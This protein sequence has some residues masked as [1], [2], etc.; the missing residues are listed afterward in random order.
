MASHAILHKRT[1]RRTAA[2]TPALQILNDCGDALPSN[3]VRNHVTYI[4]R[5]VTQHNQPQAR[6]SLPS[7]TD[8][9]PQK[10]TPKCP[11]ADGAEPI[12]TQSYTLTYPVHMH[13]C[14]KISP[15]FPPSP[16]QNPQ[17]FP[18][19]LSHSGCGNTPASSNWNKSQS[20]ALP[21][22][23]KFQKIQPCVLASYTSS[24]TS[25]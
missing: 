22:V 15:P 24:C 20:P 12:A 5:K 14:D 13:C 16:S 7:Q 25:I 23:L 11:S 3:Y 21:S 6:H 8:T 9:P 19:F 10:L 18:N 2:K 4:C 1:N 17:A